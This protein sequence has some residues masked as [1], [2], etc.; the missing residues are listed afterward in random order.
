MKKIPAFIYRKTNQIILISFVPVFA[1]IFIIVY[2]PLNF[3]NLRLQFL[4]NWGWSPEIISA[5]ISLV[6]ILVG[7]A[8][9][10]V[11][12]VI[13]GA[14]VKKRQLS[15][16]SYIGWVFSEI[17]VMSVIYTVASYI[18]DKGNFV[19][20][21]RDSLYKTVLILTIPYLLAYTFF[22]LKEKTSQLMSIRKQLE[23]D[24]K[25]LK[26]NYL[27]ILD[28]RDEL[29]LSIRRENLLFIEAEDNYVCVWYLSGN[30]V[31]NIMVRNSLKRV[32]DQM[33]DGRIVRCHRSYLIN[34]DH[35][36]ILRRERDNSFFIDLGIDGVPDIPMSKTYGEEITALMVRQA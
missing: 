10:A 35:V 25:S 5:V 14:V 12:R 9:V 21:F 20:L 33:K 2:K 36:K 1:L 11:S 32:H 18:A 8:V 27:G 29:R 3:S 19:A 31:K 13:M 30:N 24:D 26:N 23:E 6:L 16:A 22:I 17:V 28:E 4:E 15:Y 34:I 7:T